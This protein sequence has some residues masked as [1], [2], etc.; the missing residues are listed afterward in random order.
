MVNVHDKGHILAK[1]IK[2]SEEYKQFKEAK[3][4]LESNA[5]TKEMIVDF[6]KKQF[7]YQSKQLSGEEVSEEDTKKITE[8]YSIVTKDV[9][10]NK[11]LNAQMK[12]AILM[13]DVNKIISDALEGI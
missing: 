6:E 10:A 4:E 2:E 7:E 5:A 13:Q 1:A 3:K 11:Y 12:F 8:L 9:L